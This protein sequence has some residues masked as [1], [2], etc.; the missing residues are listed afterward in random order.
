VRQS[1]AYIIFFTAVMT[2]VVGG[3]LA[4]ASQGLA[5]AQKKSIELDTKTQI[6]G[7][8]VELKEGDDV[9]GMYNKR[10]KSLVVDING[11]EVQK[12]EKGGDIVA[13]N[14]SIAKNY[15]KDPEERVYPVFKFMNEENPD[16]VEAYILPLYGAGLWDKIWG[17]VAIDNQIESVV[18]VAFDHKAETPGLGARISSKE[19]QNRYKG[20]E[21]YD[22]QD[23]LVSVS[24][25]KGEGN[26]GLT[27]H[28]VDGMSGATITG[29]GVNQMLEN[30]L[31]C[32]QSYFKTVKSQKSS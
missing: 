27:E 32:Y 8:V 29:R 10:I 23:N 19:I 25:V 1:N 12:N 11:E 15:K 30:Y 18:G 4:L 31:K 21:I 22:D 7:A 5:P 2:I 20:K 14:V 17:Y 6:L 13:E 3:V 28:E 16:Q 26:A 9:L 24:M